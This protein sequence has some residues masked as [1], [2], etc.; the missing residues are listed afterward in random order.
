MTEPG[1]LES[2]RAS[3]DA[4][5][6]DYAARFAD[7]PEARPLER[8]VLAEFASLVHGTV[9]EVGSG[10]GRVTALLDALGCKV[11]G[12]DLSPEM[13]ALAT[14][15]YP[16]LKFEVGSMTALDMPDGALSGI[17]AWYSI[18]HIPDDLLPQVFAEFHRVLEPGG[19]L[20]VAFQVGDEPLCFAEAFGHAVALEVRRLQPDRI[21]ELLT[22]AGFAVR[23]RL[24]RE[25]E[26]VE[27]TPQGFLLAL[28]D[29]KPGERDRREVGVVVENVAL[30][31]ETE[32]GAQ[33]FLAQLERVE[34]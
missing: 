13:V 8:A 3:Y 20:V 26:G 10:P 2:T 18:I 32:Q 33:R 9:L 17:V 15:S 24:V 28:V 21:A 5:A 14:R 7:E 12:I 25:A 34:R 30:V 23:A 31:V 27:T 29:P 1:F 22:Q 19:C 16:G 11:F 4:I 6:V